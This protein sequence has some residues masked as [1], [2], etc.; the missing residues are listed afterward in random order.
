MLELVVPRRGVRARHE[1]G[2]DAFED[3]DDEAG[4]EED[5]PR[6]PARRAVKRRGK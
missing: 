6:R 2:A 4:D 1:E 3:E 5:R